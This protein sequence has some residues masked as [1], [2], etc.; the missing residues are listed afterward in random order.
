[1]KG[2]EAGRQVGQA[3]SG[4]N[5]RCQLYSDPK[6][7]YHAVGRRRGRRSDFPDGGGLKA[8]RQ[9]KRRSRR[10]R[11]ATGKSGGTKEAV[12]K[13]AEVSEFKQK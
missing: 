8:Q 6:P 12:M 2:R 5:R 11:G 13:A 10:R 4:Q 3:R 7:Q 9:L 1:M